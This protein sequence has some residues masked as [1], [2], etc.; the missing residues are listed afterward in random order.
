[1]QRLLR[2]RTIQAKLSI[3]RP[4]DI[5]E[6]EADWMAEQ[7]MR[8]PEPVIERTCSACA[9][10]GATCSQCETARQPRLQ[11]QIEQ[12]SD[13]SECGGMESVQRKEESP[14]KG[15]CG[16]ESVA[17]K[18]APSDKRI[19]G[20]VAPVDLDEKSFGNTSKLGADFRFGACKVDKNW[21][22]YR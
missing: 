7:A 5:Y 18:A 6:R 15:S 16:K 9:A 10:A 2:S 11:R 8:M 13:N 21:R 17:S 3:S 1:V 4:S 14:A 19:N 20:S 12:H 22:F